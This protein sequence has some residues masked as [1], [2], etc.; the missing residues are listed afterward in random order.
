MS[1][2]TVSVA[3]PMRNCPEP[4]TQYALDHNFSDLNF[5]LHTTKGLGV[6]DARNELT[7]RIQALSPRPEFTIWMDS[8]AWFELG[9]GS[10]MIAD[11]QEK[12][13]RTLIAAAACEKAESFPALAWRTSHA[14]SQL[15]QR[16]LLKDDLIQIGRVGAHLLAHR[17]DLFDHLPANPWS[18][19]GSE[20]MSITNPQDAV[21]H[22][23]RC[24]RDL[25]TAED[26]SFCR[27]V[28]GA[29][30]SIFVDPRIDAL[31]VVGEFGFKPFSKVLQ[32]INHVPQKLPT[33]VS[34]G[35]KFLQVDDDIDY[36]SG[37]S[38]PKH[39]S[40]HVVPKLVDRIIQDK[41]NLPLA[42]A[43]LR[44]SGAAPLADRIE[45]FLG[46]KQVP[47]IPL[48]AYSALR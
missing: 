15:T 39:Y 29:G 41:Q 12:D 37:L 27:R 33:G 17:T 30:G 4:E 6:I 10:R 38:R 3:M 13:P 48:R 34:V 36:G 2:P 21:A 22:L 8:D 7:R 14:E 5:T 47:T 42:L 31:H 23:I 45:A 46:G 18:L 11:L 19:F 16:D 24:Y 1:I 25:D 9:T 43:R 26:V 35:N 32:F 20:L 28:I 44:L 40:L